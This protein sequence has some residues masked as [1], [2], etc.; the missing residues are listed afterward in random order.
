M[1]KGVKIFIIQMIL[2]AAAYTAITVLENMFFGGKVDSGI[3]RG[4]IQ[5]RLADALTVLPVFTPAAIPGLFLGCLATNKAIGC[6]NL[7][8]IYGSLATLVAAIGTYV[9]RKKRFLSPIPPIVT[10]MIVVPLLFTFVYRFD[11]RPF[12][13]YVLFIGISGIISCGVLGIALML[14]LDDYKTKLFPPFRENK[15]AVKGNE[16]TKEV[17]GK[18]PEEIKGSTGDKE[19]NV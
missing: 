16:D 6:H 13:Q 5:L 10:N 2:I 3:T 11:D 1:K 19:D 17:A 15:E 4:I 9:L 8:I 14:M 7:D 18:E 12:W